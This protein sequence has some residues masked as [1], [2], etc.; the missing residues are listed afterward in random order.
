MTKNW[1]EDLK[2]LFI[3]EDIQMAN[4]KNKMCFTSLIIREMQ[5]KTRVRYYF[6][7]VR[8]T[9]IKTS[10]RQVLLRMWI[11]GNPCKLFVGMYEK[12]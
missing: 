8:M 11:K 3:K 2:R 6:I 4:G 1:A 5:I 10:K 9:I 12:Q 7:P